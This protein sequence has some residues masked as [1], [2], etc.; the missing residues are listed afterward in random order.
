MDLMEDFNMSLLSLNFVIVYI[1]HKILELLR[2]N[3]TYLKDNSILKCFLRRII[4]FYFFLI[5]S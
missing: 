4:D 3:W 5:F 1:I 2:N